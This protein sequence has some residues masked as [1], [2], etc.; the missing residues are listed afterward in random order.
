[1]FLN[2]TFLYILRCSECAGPCALETFEMEFATKHEN[3][4]TAGCRST[5]LSHIIKTY[6]ALTKEHGKCM[7]AGLPMFGETNTLY[8]KTEIKI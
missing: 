4:R 2:G 5:K 1:M 7:T 8:S 6:V 3:L